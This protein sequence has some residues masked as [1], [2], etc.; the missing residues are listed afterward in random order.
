MFYQSYVLSELCFIRA[1]FYQSY[2]LSELCFIRYRSGKCPLLVLC[3]CITSV[4]ERGPDA[5][6]YAPYGH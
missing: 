1:M 6:T 2:V 5:A 4:L 3:M